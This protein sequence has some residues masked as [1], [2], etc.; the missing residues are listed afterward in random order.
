M[1]LTSSAIIEDIRKLRKDGS[2]LVAHYYF[3][4]NDATKRDIGGLLASLLSQLSHNSDRLREILYEL[5]KTSGD[6]FERPKVSALEKCLKTMVELPGQPP[7]FIII[8]ALDECP[9]T[10][11]L[12]SARGEVLDIV[13]NL[14]RSNNPNL[15]ICITCR[16]EQDIQTVLN[17]LTAKSSHV[18]LHEESGQ[19]DD[20]I[21]Y[22]RY[23]VNTTRE[24]QT[25]TKDDKE[26][27]VNTL[28]KRAGGM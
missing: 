24:M 2:A 11:G 13:E 8:D 12:P 10:T 4:F 5:Y 15:F 28:S 21:N 7:I 19:R 16:H 14:V 18:S 26:L 1:L 3:D 17:G 23:V 22:V 9:S 27:I 25:W 20:I 6:R